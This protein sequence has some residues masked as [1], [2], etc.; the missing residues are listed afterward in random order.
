MAETPENL[1]SLIS[2]INDLMKVHC[3]QIADEYHKL[4]DGTWSIFFDHFMQHVI[5]EHQGYLWDFSVTMHPRNLAKALVLFRDALDKRVKTH[6]KDE[7][8]DD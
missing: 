1:D 5:V 7:G 8:D 2:E 3:D 4:S 6:V